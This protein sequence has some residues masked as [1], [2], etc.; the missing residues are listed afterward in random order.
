MLLF[1][2]LDPADQKLIEDIL[3]K[4]IDAL[5]VYDKA[6]LAARK[7]YISKE[8][9]KRMLGIKEAPKKEVKEKT[10]KTTKK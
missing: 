2:D 6:V 1:K 8:D 4:D 9:Y 3:R 10:K 5:T 7:D